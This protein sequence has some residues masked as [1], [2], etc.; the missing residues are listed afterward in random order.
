[1]VSYTKNTWNDGDII[2][3]DKLNNLENGIL[4]IV[5]GV[6]TTNTSIN[7][8]SN[9][10]D[11]I[12]DTINDINETVN[13]VNEQVSNLNLEN[14]TEILT[15]ATESISENR[16]VINTNAQDISNIKARINRLENHVML[17]SEY[18]DMS[19]IDSAPD[20]S[21]I[22][23]DKKLVLSNLNINNT[24][25]DIWNVSG[26]GIVL[27]GCD[28]DSVAIRLNSSEDVIIS[29][30]HSV[31]ELAKSISNA[32][33][34]IDTNETVMIKDCTSSQL[35]YNGIEIGLNNTAP[36]KVTIRN[37]DFTGNLS[38]NAISIFATADNAII[39]IENCH[40]SSVSN[41]LR[42]SNRTNANNVKVNFI[43]CSWDHLDSDTEWKSVVIC[44]DYTSASQAETIS[45]N[46][47]GNNKIEINFINC[48][49]E[50]GSITALPADGSWAG[51]GEG[52]LIYV[53]ANKWANEESGKVPY[54]D[55]FEMFPD[56][57][58]DTSL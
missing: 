39:T 4:S 11:T 16:A 41:V 30:N 42:L 29:D 8:I 31:G 28:S 37:C 14:I 52:K 33:V 9:N 13:T 54:A 27:T 23:S 18:S 36:K 10:V 25:G 32:A 21:A 44:Q 55:Y 20:T 50:N 43:N 24:N 46:R 35:G 45:A 26:K 51:T 40:F 34:S 22:T 57:G 12:T 49:G 2:T 38:N 19:I 3:A 15:D 17:F 1:M 56:I 6:N 5:D 47:F 48:T 7:D 58:V 53:Y